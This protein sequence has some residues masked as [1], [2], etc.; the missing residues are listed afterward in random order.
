ML[1]LEWLIGKRLGFSVIQSSVHQVESKFSLIN[2]QICS[3]FCPKPFAKWFVYSFHYS[4][5]SY[6]IT[7]PKGLVCRGCTL[8]LLRQARE[9]GHRYTF[10]SCADVD[11]VPVTNIMQDR[12]SVCSGNGHF[13]FYD[14]K[15]YCNRLYSGIVCQFTGRYIHF[16]PMNWTFF[17]LLFFPPPLSLSIGWKSS[18]VRLIVFI[19]SNSLSWV[20]P[21]LSNLSYIY[22]SYG[23]WL[24]FSLHLGEYFYL[25]TLLSST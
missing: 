19:Y 6:S 2:W 10:W 17:F 18:I 20:L 16:R 1:D 22:I 12:K 9:W 14:G 3:N 13:N 5:Q 4:A 24:T 15:C 11:I 8:R 21:F 7:L 25:F 23:R